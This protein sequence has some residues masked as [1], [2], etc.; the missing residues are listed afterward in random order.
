MASFSDSRPLWRRVHS[1]I[2]YGMSRYGGSGAFGRLA[3][4]LGFWRISEF[5]QRRKIIFNEGNVEIL[6][7][8]KRVIRKDKQSRED[9]FISD[10]IAKHGGACDYSEVKYENNS[11]K[12]DIRC[13]KH[14]HVFQQNSACHLKA[15]IPCPLCR[16][17]KRK[18]KVKQ[19]FI[20]ELEGKYP[21]LEV[22]DY[23]HGARGAHSEATI[24]F[25]A[26]GH[27]FHFKNG[28]HHMLN[29]GDECP[30]CHPRSEHWGNSKDK[31][32]EE[33][34]ARLGK[35]HD[36]AFGYDEIEFTGNKKDK[37]KILCKKHKC[38]F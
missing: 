13:V 1:S 37:A 16:E 10:A 6:A 2:M 18:E 28:H 27:T 4:G 32:L 5:E 22:V 25:T 12:L 31:R 33:T 3:S 23:T 34:K 26:C 9:K 15:E 7:E 8:G 36:N 14:N 17:E 24:L 11:Q 20:K 30:T 35:I 21:N 19:K 38:H 29:R